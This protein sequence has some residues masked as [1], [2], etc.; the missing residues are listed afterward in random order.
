MLRVRLHLLLDRSSQP[1]FP[2]RKA[3][4]F[5]TEQTTRLVLPSHIEAVADAAAAAAD[6]ARN[7]GLADEAA[8]GIDMAG[9]ESITK[10]IVP[11]NKK[12]ETKTSEV[13]FNSGHPVVGIEV[14]D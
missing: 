3:A 12:D 9:C 7:C 5:V 10:P 11:G 14:A 6:F 2:A 4:P 1:H 8:F 13:T